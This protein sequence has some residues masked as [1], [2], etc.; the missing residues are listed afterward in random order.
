MAV[1]KRRNAEKEA[2]RDAVVEFGPVVTQQMAML[3][4][5]ATTESRIV[6]LGCHPLFLV[7]YEKRVE[8]S[9][10][11]TMNVEKVRPSGGW[12]PPGRKLH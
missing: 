11:H 6:S 4:F 7:R 12:L 3:A 10:M 1:S 2:V 9:M 8:P 5:N